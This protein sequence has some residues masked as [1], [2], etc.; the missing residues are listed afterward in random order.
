MSRRPATDEVGKPAAEERFTESE[1]RASA[2]SLR[3]NSSRH[4]R[5]SLRA[6]RQREACQQLLLWS[7]LSRTPQRCRHNDLLAVLPSGLG[8]PTEAPQHAYCSRLSPT[9]AASKRRTFSKR[10]FAPRAMGTRPPRPAELRRTSTFSRPCPSRAGA[11][12]EGD[13]APEGDGRKRRLSFP[14]SAR[15]GTHLCASSRYPGRQR[16][17]AVSRALPFDSA[18]AH[19]GALHVADAPGIGAVGLFKPRFEPARSL[20]H[21]ATL[22][23][24]TGIRSSSD[25]AH[26]FDDVADAS[27]PGG[28]RRIGHW[29]V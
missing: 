15:Q 19:L 13:E 24:S 23:G 11:E 9:K 8:L 25:S 2:R 22:K 10:S 21:S 18:L 16:A 5:G 20:W 3:H 14:A 26:R 27:V 29:I 4:S 12:L 1:S 6:A 17:R 28:G 7:G